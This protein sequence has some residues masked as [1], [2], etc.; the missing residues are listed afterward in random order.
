MEIAHKQAILDYWTLVEFF[1]PYLLENVLD[2]KKRYQK[3]YADEPLSC[4]LPWYGSEVISENDP[5]TPFAKGYHLYLGLFSIAETADRARHVF[6]GQKSEWQSMNWKDC[7]EGSSITAFARLSVS[8]HGVPLFGSLSL[9]TLPWAHGKLLQQRQEL[10]NIEEFWKSVNRLLID[11]REKLFLPSKLM[12][13]PELE[14]GF[15]DVES[16]FS[17]TDL[18]FKWADFRPSGY[19]LVLIEPVEG[20]KAV[21]D[22]GFNSSRNVPIL[23]SFYIHDLESARISLP[24]QMGMPIDQYLSCKQERRISIESE[25]GQLEILK[26][27]LPENTPSGRWPDPTFQ[28][29]SLMQQFAINAAF[30]TMDEKG[31]FSVNGPPGTGKTSLLR[32]IVAEN[33]VARAH[34]LSQFKSA[35]EA[36]I[37]KHAISFEGFDAI[38]ISELDPSLTGFEMVIV[39]SNNTAVQNVSRELPL[40]SQLAT[41]FQHA[42]YLEP[43]AAKVFEDQAWGLISASLGNKENCQNFV[44]KLFIEPGDAKIRIWEWI[45]DYRGPSFLDAKEAFIKLKLEQERLFEEL[46]RLAYLHE[47][48]SGKALESYSASELKALEEVE[49]KLEKAEETLLKLRKEEDEEKDLI[50]LL[51]EQEELLKKGRRITASKAWKAKLALIRADRLK[52]TK[53]L[54]QCKLAQ[55]ELREQKVFYLEQE[56]TLTELLLDKSLLFHLLSTEYEALKNAHLEVDLHKALNQ[57]ETHYQTSQVNQ[58]R[59]ELFIAALKLHEAWLAETLRAKG[60][61]RGNL[62]A[63]SNILQ[64]KSPTTADDTRRVWQSLFMLIPVI[65]ST[66]ASIR[67]LFRFLEPGSIGWLLID[68][69]GQASPQSAVGAIWRA[70][71]VFCIGDPFQI[72][73]IC[74][75]PEEVVDG[76][77][78][79]RLQDHM[80]H[81]ASSQ[82]S[83]QQVFD[84]ISIFGSERV[85]REESYWVSSPLRLHRRCLEPMFTIANSIAYESSMVNATKQSEEISLP[86]SCWWDVK[87]NVTRKQY[88]SEQGEA[89]IALLNE[90]LLQIKTPDFYIISPFREVI[91]QLASL[92]LNNRELKALFQEQFPA[93]PYSAWVRDSTGTVH[94]FQGKQ[95]LA[96]FFVLGG[97]RST[98]GALDWASRKPNLL[99]VA[100]TR[101][102]SRFYVVGDYDLWKTR[103]YFDVAAKKLERRKSG[104]PGA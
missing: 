65:S 39:S 84:R 88:V 16:L 12:K 64:G 83:V 56:R 55:K 87:G 43:L 48:I 41:A 89:L 1:S 76:M 61:F 80:L 15:L 25:E 23:N 71:R 29:Q 37:G 49:N 73:P 31:I 102:K 36:F 92:L 91:D 70:K 94:T 4:P 52:E 20:G 42:S 22:L 68:E 103:P 34:V 75:I 77:A 60:G 93:I 67:R 58:V 44:E 97:D 50:T 98:F 30:E 47:E 72:E 45:D 66:F 35:Q 17:L 57:T 26:A 46:G 63:I 104:F 90:M 81:W 19:P 78:K 82:L 21:K 99:N 13:K 95:A 69:A 3:I 38:A 32:E 86:A 18:L 27:V 100:V 53:Q 28:K 79:I 101:A 33:I 59:S 11:L 9:S 74:Q 96:V 85:L 24:T 14:A 54:H 6:S 8:T 5:Q 51:K 62:M 40:R 10:L 2:S 7:G